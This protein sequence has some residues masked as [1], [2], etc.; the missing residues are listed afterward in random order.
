MTDESLV[1]PVQVDELTQL[2]EKATLLGIEFSNN[3]GVAKL[4]ERINDFLGENQENEDKVQDDEAPKEK[5]RQDFINEA[6]RLV[7]IRVT[8]MN[9]AKRELPGE[10][11][12]VANGVIGTVS[13]YI[14]YGGGTNQG[15]HVPAV[16]L[17]AMKRRTFTQKV[18]KHTPDG[19]V[20]TNI[21]Q[22][23]FAIEVLPPLT[24]AELEKLARDQRAADR[25]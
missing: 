15:Y 6:T 16:I 4:R 25:I 5:T 19:D 20:W 2:K 14:P 10:I 24:E 3:I 23:E 17:K 1:Q 21:K 22:R 9:P 11:I 7:R 13:K 12:T 18:K 8:N